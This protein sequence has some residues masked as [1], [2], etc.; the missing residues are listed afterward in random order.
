[1]KRE[2]DVEMGKWKKEKHAKE[3]G[4]VLCGHLGQ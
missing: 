4:L 1:M 3:G 2:R